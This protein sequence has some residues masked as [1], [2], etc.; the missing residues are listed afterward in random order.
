M[1]CIFEIY[2]NVLHNFG[3]CTGYLYYNNLT[4]ILIFFL[5]FKPIKDKNY[6]LFS[7]NY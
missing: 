5:H 3:N 2:S 1:N 4:Y 6:F 7:Y